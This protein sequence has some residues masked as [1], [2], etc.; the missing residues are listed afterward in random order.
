MKKKRLKKIIAWSLGITGLLILVLAVHIYIVT[1]PGKPDA[2]TISMARIDIQPGGPAP[3]SVKIL[4]WLYS[5]Q[6]VS[7]VLYNPA[8]RIA[9]FTYYPA[10]VSADSI[11]N[12]FK[13]ELSLNAGRVIATEK[14]LQNG[15]PVAATSFTYKA[16][17]FFKNHF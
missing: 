12:H 7:H 16:Y 14:D 6:G 5:Q 8:A 11:T 4:Q 10:Q 1:R 15:C 17:Q 9:V 3:D 2:T 13:H